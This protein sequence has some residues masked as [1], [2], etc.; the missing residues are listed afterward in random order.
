MTS[1]LLNPGVTLLSSTWR[2]ALKAIE[3]LLK[4][5]FKFILIEV[6]LIYNVSFSGV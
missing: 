6:E 3:S 5:F 1:L 4:I 2:V